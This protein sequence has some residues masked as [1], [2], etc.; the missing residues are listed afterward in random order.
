M[1]C[2]LKRSLEGA[3]IKDDGR[4]DAHRDFSLLEGK[5]FTRATCTVHMN[6]E[7]SIYHAKEGDFFGSTKGS[8]FRF[9]VSFS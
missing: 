7:I 1:P 6:A 8:F 5:G 2:F 4:P 9:K 3:G